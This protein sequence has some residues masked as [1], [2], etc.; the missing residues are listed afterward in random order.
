RG[1]RMVNGKLLVSSIYK[2][3]QVDFGGSEEGV[4]QHLRQYAEE[5]LAESLRTYSK[6][7]RDDYDWS[8]NEP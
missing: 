3:F 6:G 2:W 8:L 7:L 5:D 1:A 4:I